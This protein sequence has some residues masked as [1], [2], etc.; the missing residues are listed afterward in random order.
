MPC[1][2][3]SVFSG[4]LEIVK[5]LHKTRTRDKLGAIRLFR[6]RTILRVPDQTYTI[7]D[8]G[9]Y[10][11]DT[12]VKRIAFF[13]PEIETFSTEYQT[14]PTFYEVIKIAEASNWWTSMMYLWIVHV[15]KTHRGTPEVVNPAVFSNSYSEYK[16]VL[17]F[18]FHHWGTKYI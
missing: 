4:K 3:F 2:F 13:V 12:A 15:I 18:E 9:N 14:K 6:A 1:I 17:F 5:V 16:T 10:T 7:G 11:A 8:W